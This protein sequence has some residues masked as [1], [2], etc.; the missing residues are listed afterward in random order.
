MP[1]D[2][3]GGARTARG[4]DLTYSNNIRTN[5][6]LSTTEYGVLRTLS[7]IH[8]TLNY[9]GC[10]GLFVIALS[11]SPGLSTYDLIDGSMVH[12]IWHMELCMRSWQLTLK[13]RYS[14][15]DKIKEYEYYKRHT[16]PCRVT[17]GK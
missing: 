13:K 4:A 16:Q 1:S 17:L 3:D 12:D 5:V 10:G 2:Q 14:T 7:T 11:F 9:S 8:T 6:T 15:E